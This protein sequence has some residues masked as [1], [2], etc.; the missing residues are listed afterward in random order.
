MALM[1]VANRPDLDIRLTEH[2]ADAGSE[3]NQNGGERKD[4]VVGQPGG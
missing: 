3:Q 1:T 4:R 2:E